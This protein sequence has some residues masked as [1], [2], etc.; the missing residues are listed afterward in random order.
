M[1]ITPPSLDK[2]TIWAT[3][4]VVVFL[5]GCIAGIGSGV[6]AGAGAGTAAALP[7][8]GVSESSLSA[9]LLAASLAAGGNGIKRVVV[10]HDANPMPN[11]FISDQKS[12][13]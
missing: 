2:L 8:G 4:A 3:E 10:W 6:G 7:A 9:A 12:S 1:K 11:P 13:A 5:N